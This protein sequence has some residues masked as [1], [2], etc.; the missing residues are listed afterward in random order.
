MK[1]GFKKR[2]S[3]VLVLSLL[4]GF[5]TQ[6]SLGQKQL[7]AYAASDN[8]YKQRFL[9]IWEE[10]HD[11]ANGYFSSHGIPYHSIETLIIEAP[12]YG[13]VTTSEAMSYY[14]WLEAMYGKFT[15]DFSYL[16]KHGKPS[17]ST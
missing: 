12:D 14:L 8:P 16:I 13:H 10:L 6:L 5:V 17:K 9:E 7:T 2:I 3:W 1:K 11:P 4:L 15:G